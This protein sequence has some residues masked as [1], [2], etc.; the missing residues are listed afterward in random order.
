MLALNAQPINT[1]RAKKMLRVSHQA[2]TPVDAL[3]DVA[4]DVVSSL[5]P[6]VCL[7]P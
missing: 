7:N 1:T 3:G 5:I 6:E 2:L 4:G